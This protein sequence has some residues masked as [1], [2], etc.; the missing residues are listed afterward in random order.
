MEANPSNN[1]NY[2]NTIISNDNGGGTISATVATND[3]NN[4]EVGTQNAK[5]EFL[6]DIR[7]YIS[8]AKSIAFV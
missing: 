3:N 4:N 1:D 7:G 8:P 5:Q 6:K 2:N